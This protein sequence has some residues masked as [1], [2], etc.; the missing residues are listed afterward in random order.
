MIIFGLS[1]NSV[2]LTKNKA[3]GL[4]KLLDFFLVLKSNWAFK[5]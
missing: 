5:A 3:I 4:G 2:N 1:K